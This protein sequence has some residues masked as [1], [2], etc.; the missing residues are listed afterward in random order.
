MTTP[1]III[2]SFGISVLLSWLIEYK[3]YFLSQSI[4]R[5]ARIAKN[6]KVRPVIVIVITGLIFLFL[7][8]SNFPDEKIICYGFFFLIVCGCAHFDFNYQLIP[9][10]LI[11]T[12]IF[13]WFVI[14]SLG[15]ISFLPSVISGAGAAALMFLIR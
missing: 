11:L 9:N 2:L 10:R 6:I 15:P 1:L 13:G 14:A 3:P 12:G 7:F 5:D 4:D 8:T